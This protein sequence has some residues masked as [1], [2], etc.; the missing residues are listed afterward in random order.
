ML[1]SV[2]QIQTAMQTT[3]IMSTI[4]M[5]HV[6]IPTKIDKIYGTQNK[7]LRL[8]IVRSNLLYFIFIKDNLELD[9]KQ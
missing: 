1:M 3:T 2:T 4:L 6:Q 5:G 8:F 7:W 9:W